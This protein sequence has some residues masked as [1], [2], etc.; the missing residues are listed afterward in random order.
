[1]FTRTSAALRHPIHCVLQLCPRPVL[2]CLISYV[3]FV[4]AAF[5]QTT[6]TYACRVWAREADST[7][8]LKPWLSTLSDGYATT[9]IGTEED[10]HTIW[11][12]T[13]ERVILNELQDRA[14]SVGYTVFGYHCTS[15]V[16]GTTFQEGI[17][18]MPVLVST[19]DEVA[20]HARYAAAK[21]Q[22]I[23]T[24]PRAY[25]FVM[26]PAQTGTPHEK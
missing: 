7:T 5:A 16:D 18:P 4:P 22:W 17:P 23:N 9:T 13:D 3:L 12:H 10:G 21:A 24:Y 1:M 20:D 8:S 14:A 25:A 6:G 2:C 11:L 15:I 19:G 26:D